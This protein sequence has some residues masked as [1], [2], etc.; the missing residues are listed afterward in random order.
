MCHGTTGRVQGPD[1]ADGAGAVRGV[2]RGRAADRCPAS[3]CAGRPAAGGGGR[4]GPAG[5]PGGG[6]CGTGGCGTV[7][8]VASAGQ[9][10]GAAAGHR[11]LHL[12]RGRLHP[13]AACRP[14]G[15]L[16]RRLALG[17]GRSAGPD[18]RRAAVPRWPAA[19]PP[20]AAGPGPRRGSRGLLAAVDRSRYRPDR[21]SAPGEPDRVARRGRPG[22]VG[23]V[24]HDRPGRPADHGVGRGGDRAPAPAPGHAHRP[25]PRPGRARRLGMR[26]VVVGLHRR[27]LGPG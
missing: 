22:D 1:R 24:R 17:A 7:S 20:V 26:A 2:Q 27:D 11:R 13:R 15:R 12:R 9:R 8:R 6:G 5:H 4:P 3:P 18:R 19:V 23:R 25:G 16:A 10:G 21:L 14:V